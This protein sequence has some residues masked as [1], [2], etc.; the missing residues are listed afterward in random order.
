MATSPISPTSSLAS[1]AAASLKLDDL[2]KVM[3]TEL[4]HQN[5]FKPVENKDFM[6]Q[7]AQFG[8]LDAAQRLNSNIEQMLALQAI[9]QSV[10]LVGKTVSAV[11]DNVTIAGTVSR[12]TLANGVPRL[13]INATDGQVFPNVAIG[14]LT[15]VTNPS[16]P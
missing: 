13:T 8:S 11:V 12:L 14:Q 6:A 4:T 9:T 15:T 16:Q 10:G 2:L 7:I 5:P 3:L 1:N